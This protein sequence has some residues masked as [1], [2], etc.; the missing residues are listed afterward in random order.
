[1]KLVA[2][3]QEYILLLPI[4]CHQ[5]HI[6]NKL[7]RVWNFYIIISANQEVKINFRLNFH[8][9]PILLEVHQ[10]LAQTL[11]GVL[12]ESGVLFDLA[13]ELALEAFFSLLELLYLSIVDGLVKYYL[14][15]VY[16]LF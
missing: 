12:G 16:Y 4:L 11:L 2:R 3:Q 5:K 6:L 8:W 13:E 10:K 9:T 7:S 14:N 1:L 15:M